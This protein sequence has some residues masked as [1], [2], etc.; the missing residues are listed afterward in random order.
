M[1]EAASEHMIV[2]KTPPSVSHVTAG[3]VTQENFLPGHE[4]PVSW[5]GVEDTESGIRMIEVGNGSGS[6][7]LNS[8]K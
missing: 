7:K 4:V 5:E 3:T 2:D 1:T 8:Q 6:L